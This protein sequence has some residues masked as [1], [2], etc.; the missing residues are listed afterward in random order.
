MDI[1]R[2]TDLTS[3]EK[4]FVFKF[5]DGQDIYKDARD[6]KPLVV[7]IVKQI[8]DENAIDIGDINI[9]ALVDDIHIH[10]S[11]LTL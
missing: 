1:A 7:E 6:I 9:D 4:Q 2:N 8:K 3:R 11:Q 5:I 10:D